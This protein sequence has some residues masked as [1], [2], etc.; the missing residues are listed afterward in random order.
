MTLSRLAA[1]AALSS[2]L[3]AAGP[4]LYGGKPLSYWTD[5][6]DK[7]S[8]GRGSERGEDPNVV[9]AVEA[10]KALGRDGAAAA[11]TLEK[12]ISATD[13]DNSRVM[14]I[15]ALPVLG[16]PGTAALLK[17]LHA[18]VNC[19]VHKGGRYGCRDDDNTL[20][21][22]LEGIQRAGP[23]A[24][25]AIPD[26]AWLLHHQPGVERTRSRRRGIG[27]GLVEHVALTL[28]GFGDAALNEAVK[29]APADAE[30][31]CRVAA[32]VEQMSTPAA[33]KMALQLA[34][35]DDVVVQRCGAEALTEAFRTATVEEQLAW[36]AENAKSTDVRTRAA[37][38]RWVRSLRWSFEPPAKKGEKREKATEEQETAGEASL[39]AICLT[40][41]SDKDPDVR[42]E[43]VVTL[44][45]LASHPEIEAALKR[46]KSDPDWFVR[47]AASS[48][49]PMLDDD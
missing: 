49:Q 35:A 32:V 39:R 43:T 16:P 45:R 1:V 48:K 29:T 40:L 47:R 28:S 7:A 9:E 12:F 6:I 13:E 38:A 24:Q 30:G 36:L 11:P 22:V 19:P 15:Q 26:L 23:D 31:Q 46:A 25:G 3:A 20:M 41:A 14:A 27:G 5:I 4:R 44:Q 21:L 2:T 18:N 17:L 10:I 8:V 37:A 34:R 33:R 42:R